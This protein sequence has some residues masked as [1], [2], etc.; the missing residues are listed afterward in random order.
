MRAHAGKA[1]GGELVKVLKEAGQPVPD[2]LLKYDEGIVKKK[3]HK[4]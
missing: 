3:D 4:V 2:D 1:H